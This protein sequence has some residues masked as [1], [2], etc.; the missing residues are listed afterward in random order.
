MKTLLLLVLAIYTPAV[1]SQ[2]FDNTIQDKLDLAKSNASLKFDYFL[3]QSSFPKNY[4]ETLKRSF[5]EFEYDKTD[6]KLQFADRPHVKKQKLDSLI[7]SFHIWKKLQFQTYNVAV[8]LWNKISLRYNFKNEI[9][10]EKY[11]DYHFYLGLD[12]NSEIEI[13]EFVKS[14]ESDLLNRAARKIAEKEANLVLTKC[15]GLEKLDSIAINHADKKLYEFL[16]S[17]ALK[18]LESHS[19][20]TLKKDKL[21]Y[22]QLALN[23]GNKKQDSLNSYKIESKNKAFISEAEALGIENEKAN[24]I[25]QLIDKRTNDLKVKPSQNN[26]D[27]MSELFNNT[28]SKTKQEIKNE[29]SQNLARLINKTEFAQLFGKEFTKN[30]LNKTQD[31]MN[32]LSQIYDLTDEQASQI[33][34]LAK[35]FYFNQEVIKAY[36]L[37][38][39]KLQKQ[40]LSAL[41]YRFVKNYQ[42]LMEALSLP[43]NPVNKTS[44]RTFQWD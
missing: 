11:I 31:K 21:F 30:T 2:E 23:A 3:D 8:K 5:F 26:S 42:E 7:T 12:A 43:I 38:D 29:F 41:N 10:K 33:K 16:E 20:L 27:N 40:K 25:L 18:K 19:I 24:S 28:N 39:K 44:K 32:E 34:S 22:C 1:H 37:F 35:T 15:K 13:L 9:F 36:F 6:V 4:H 17:K 14:S